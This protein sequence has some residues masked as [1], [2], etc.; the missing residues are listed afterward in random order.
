MSLVS[1]ALKAI[2][3]FCLVTSCLA[4]LAV[5]PALFHYWIFL[6][7]PAKASLE[8]KQFFI[9]PGT[10]AYKVSQLLESKEV[11]RN[12]R[13]FYLLAWLN[14]SLHRLQ[15]GEYA[16][17]TLSTPEQVLEKIVGGRVVIH[18]VTF[19]EGS[20]IRDVAR[21]FEQK[22]LVT[23]STILDLAKSPSFIR[24]LGLQGSSLEG[25]LFPE[26]YSFKRPLEG[27]SAIRSMVNQF[28]QHMPREWQTRSRD[29]G[30][31]LNQLV[32]LASIIE[33]E[34]IVDSE[35]PVIAGVF[36]N[37][38]KINMPLQSDPTAVYDI[39]D[40][41]GPVTSNHLTRQSPY[42]TYQ[43]K[44]L[45]PGPICSPGAKSLRAALYPEKVP[46]LYF[47]SN[48]DGTHYFSTT[49]EEHRKA[50]ARYYQKKKKA[51]ENGSPSPSSLKPEGPVKEQPAQAGNP[52]EQGESRDSNPVP[53][54]QGD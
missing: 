20:T 32:T 2:F 6:R 14:K 46:Y 36:Y 53:A 25:Y 8:T 16:F 31:N 51:E 4:V 3:S 35:R 9:P 11:I 24:S 54:V 42:N 44:G 40:F 38:L 1:K 10:G 17:L 22:E 48:Y 5:I 23:G 15:A 41:S 13:A 45:P 50:V 29:L 12:A 18:S 19:V 30:L 7:L 52:P 28:W 49:I 21:M 37:R 43:I 26:T 27:A 47:V 39:P 34:A 33:K